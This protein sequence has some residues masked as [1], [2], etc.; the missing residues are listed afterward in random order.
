MPSST[1]ESSLSEGAD[2]TSSEG[3]DE[4]SPDAE[5]ETLT[6]TVECANCGRRFV[7]T[8][9]PNCGQ[10]ADPSRSSTAVIGDFFREMVDVERGF[11]T[12][13]VGLTLR[14]G[15]TLNRYLEG[16]RVGQ[17]SPGRYLLVAALALIGVKRLLVA[18]GA[19]PPHVEDP[20]VMS[21]RGR[22][23]FEAASNQLASVL[24]GQGETL[25]LLL[26]AS[27]L[28]PLLWRLFPERISRGAEALGVGALM[29]GH[30]L[31][32]S[33]G[34]RLVDGLVG[35]LV[36]GPVREVG[37]G[38]TFVPDDVFIAALPLYI[39]AATF[40]LFNSR[41]TS[42]L[43]GAVAIAWA[44]L[45][46]ISVWG[47]VV[48]GYAVWLVEAHPADYYMDAFALPVV[49]AVFAAPLLLHAVGEAY[50]RLRSA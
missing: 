49:T 50:W 46:M 7:G 23:V 5:E 18:I 4:T 30:A 10:E 48:A 26:L 2:E 12:T 44:V 14:P 15:E 16:V 39:G 45:E 43:K 29:T 31:L 37:A 21:K 41:W 8:Y 17:A 47:L 27:L 9:C 38:A 13:F 11:S 28:A 35:R 19:R 1:P 42:A 40:A 36:K 34:A 24:Y 25:L 3:T 32:L 33:A 6:P 22:E 20:Y